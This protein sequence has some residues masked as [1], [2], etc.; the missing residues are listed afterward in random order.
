MSERQNW[1]IYRRGN[2]ST[3]NLQWVRDV[4]A[5]T[6]EEA[7]EVA[8]VPQGK[9]VVVDLNYTEIHTATVTRPIRVVP[10]A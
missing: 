8:D 10:D 7:L 5:A 3:A 2:N 4:N 9:Y 1:K 6:A